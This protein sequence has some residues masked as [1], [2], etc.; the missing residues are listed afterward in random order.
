M[1]LADLVD[2]LGQMVI[3]RND[4]YDMVEILNDASQK[5]TT[6]KLLLV[7]HSQGNFYANALYDAIVD[8]PGYN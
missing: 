3:D 2:V 6:Q 4:D 8:E 7:G 1:G 5:V